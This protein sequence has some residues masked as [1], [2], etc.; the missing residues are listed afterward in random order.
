MLYR[1]VFCLLVVLHMLGVVQAQLNLPGIFS[2]H[3]VLQQKMSI[4]IWGSG[5]PGKKVSVQF[6]GQNK[7]TVCNDKGNWQISL[8]AMTASAEG[9]QLLVSD[10]SSSI[11]INDV[12]V[13]EVWIGSGQSNMGVSLAE[14][15]DAENVIAN[16]SNPLIRIIKV[17]QTPA[18]R[19]RTE[20]NAKWLISTPANAKPFSA[21][22]YFFA[23]K[24]QKELQVPVGIVVCAWGGSSVLAWMSEEA[25]SKGEMRSIAPYDQIG[26]FENHRPKLLYNGMLHPLIPLAVKGILW[27]Q[28]ETDAMDER[29]NPYRYRIAFRSM[30]DDWR[31]AWKRSDMPFYF[32]QL[33]NLY[34]GKYWP[35]LRESQDIVNR[36]LQHTGMITT[37]DIGQSRKLH[38]TNKSQFADRLA[39]L[40]LAEQYKKTTA[41][42]FPAFKEMNI[43]QGK[44]RIA[45][46]DADGLKTSDGKDPLSFEIAGSDQVFKPALATIEGSSILVW[47]NEV[48]APVAVRYAFIP[49][50]TVNLVNKDGLPARPFRTDAWD[51]FGSDLI[52]RPLT[53]K[54]KLETEFSPQDILDEKYSDWKWLD[55]KYKKEELI[56]DKS[57]ARIGNKRIRVQV[58]SRRSAKKE[59]GAV[60]AWKKSIADPTNGITFEAA[61]EMVRANMTYSGFSLQAGIR[62]ND[63][64]FVYKIEFTP[65]SIMM[66]K[67]EFIYVL[68]DDMDN[69]DLHQYRIA[70]RKD[71]VCQVYYDEQ[72]IGVASPEIIEDK[73]MVAKGSYILFG[74]VREEGDIS[75]NVESVS[76]DGTGAYSPTVKNGTIR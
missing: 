36:S 10:G 46:N 64:L 57:I 58:I 70:I 5:E 26:Y 67:E 63:R 13:G 23:Q 41:S 48:Q 22:G 68:G 29:F 12:L 24:L 11:K 39:D 60:V 38:P 74:K 75:T 7:E 54:N 14:V 35:V 51:V 52:G 18:L 69:S 55:N 66:M 37:I 4:P 47:N 19:P 20:V 61:A 53:V 42:A 43:K 76:F 9:R 25:L 32:V 44:A 50:P 56:K 62:E 73:E 72:L 6:G 2:D 49:D 40:V 45:F 8:E 31:N 15:D 34:G 1:R 33:P 21:I 71:G 59:A 17:P 3:M 65:L 16:A 28:G 27:Y 30:I